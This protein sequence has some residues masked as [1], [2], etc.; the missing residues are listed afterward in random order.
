MIIEPGKGEE[1]KN[2]VTLYKDVPDLERFARTVSAVSGVGNWEE[3]VCMHHHEPAG[4]VSEGVRECKQS[5][6]EGEGLLEY[7]SIVPIWRC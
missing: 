5:K 4:R 7:C 2:P 6:Q 3:L 1:K